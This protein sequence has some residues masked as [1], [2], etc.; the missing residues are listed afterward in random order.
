MAP[1]RLPFG[2][3]VG[4]GYAR[5]DSGGRFDSR[6]EGIYVRGDVVVPVGP[7]LAVTA[8]VGYEDIQASQRDLLRDATGVPVLDARRRPIAGS[9][10]RRACSPTTIDGVMYD[11]GVIWRP[12]PRTELQARA[13]HR[14]GGTTFTG[15]LDHQFNDASGRATPRC[16]TA[17]R[18]SA[19]C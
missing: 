4:A 3:T 15:S 6:F 1:G 11:A 2:W 17:S 12:S 5:E 18:R 8:G 14:Y 16:S 19:A 10:P 9:R 13:G 7:T